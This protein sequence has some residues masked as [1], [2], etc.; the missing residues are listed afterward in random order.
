[1]RA[2]S[3]GFTVLEVMVASTILFSAIMVYMSAMLTSTQMQSRTI[4]NAR[5][6]DAIQKQVE[7]IQNLTAASVRVKNG[8][9]IMDVLNNNLAIGIITVSDIPDSTRRVL[10]TLTATGADMQGHSIVASLEYIH[11]ERGIKRISAN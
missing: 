3:S 2:P 4:A 9:P 5:V 1:M 11:T 6:Y 10:V 7:E 8:K